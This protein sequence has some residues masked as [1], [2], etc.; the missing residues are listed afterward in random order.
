MAGPSAGVYV[1]ELDLSDEVPLVSSSTGA[2]VGASV[3]GPVGAPVFISTVNQFIQ[4]FGEPNPQVSWMHYQALTFLEESTS[5]WVTRVAGA[6]YTYGGLV[7]QNLSSD[8]TAPA[9]SLQNVAAANPLGIDFSTAGSAT[10]ATQNFAYIYAI[11]PGSYSNNIAVKIVSD[12]VAKPAGVTAVGATIV[13]STIPNGAYSYK[14]TAIGAAGESLPSV[15]A[16]ATT[17]GGINAVT[18]SWPAVAG[19]IGYK[20]YG[21]TA[22]AEYY[23]GTLASQVLTA[24]DTFTA[25]TYIDPAT[26][27][28]GSVVIP[29]SIPVVIPP[30]ITNY[31]FSKEFKVQV[32]DMLQSVFFPVEEYLCSLDN[33]L[34]GFGQQKEITQKIN[35]YSNFIRVVSNAISFPLGQP[36]VYS[37]AQTRLVVG[38]SGSAVTS[39]DIAN[40]WT[41]YQDVEAIDVQ[42]LI[43][44]GYANPTVQLKMDTVAKLRGDAVSILD[45]PAANQKAQAAVDYRR[46][47]LNLNSNRSAIYTPDLLIAD[48]YNNKTLFIPPAGHAASVYARTD[49]VAEAWFAPAGLN[50]GILNVQDVRVRYTKGDRDLLQ[51]SQINY[52]RFFPGQGKAIFEQRTLQANNTALSFMN[53]RRLMD[54][55][56]KS[57]SRSL[58]YNVF[59]PNDD[60]TRRQIVEKCRRYLTYIKQRRGINQFEVVCDKRNNPP[61]IT[62]QGQLNVDIYVTPILPAEKIQLTAVITRQG[63]NFQELINSQVTG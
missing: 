38:S 4:L 60:F 48:T 41:Q 49:R 12:N 19:A 13:G 5:L 57:I 36:A 51:T 37:V 8:L 63:A 32:F 9:F 35:P 21:R 56:E 30:T 50:R 2:I 29:G 52:T 7:L 33:A 46:L 59:D 43:N 6:G 18:L 55:L 40:G 53:V 10:L 25:L 62:G 3:K 26:G 14:I 47:V 28:P 1:R 31:V 16:V 44:G 17:T 42:L 24:V 11:G 58:L 15:A 54:I 20:I 22:G 27:L 34:D 23:L 45:M 39:S 61:Y